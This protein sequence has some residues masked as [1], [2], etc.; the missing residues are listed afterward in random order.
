MATAT[1]S[2]PADNDE[3]DPSVRNLQLSTQLANDWK[4]RRITEI[5]LKKDNPA[6]WRWVATF[7]VPA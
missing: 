2:I 4:N 7:E 1:D 5:D 3:L 6:A